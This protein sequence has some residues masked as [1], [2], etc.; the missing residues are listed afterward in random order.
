MYLCLQVPQESTASGAPWQRSPFLKL[1]EREHPVGTLAGPPGTAVGLLAALP[2]N[3]IAAG[4][5]H[6]S[7]DTRGEETVR[8]L[9]CHHKI[10]HTVD[11]TDI[12]SHSPGDWMSQVRVLA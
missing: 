12:C 10:L 11:F 4:W 6:C 3:H 9:R 8:L 7:K 2:P 5:S 1:W